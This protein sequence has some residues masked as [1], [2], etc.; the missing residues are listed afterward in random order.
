MR[1]F[2]FTIA[3]TFT[4]LMQPVSVNAENVERILFSGSEL[5]Y[6]LPKGFCNVTESIQGIILKDIIDKQKNPMVPVAQLI[7]SPCEPNITN[8]GYPWGWIGVIK[9]PS[10]LRQETLNKMTVKL[11]TDEDLVEKVLKQLEDKNT[12]VVKEFY[13]VDTKIDSNEQRV[14]W[15]DKDSILLVGNR[16]GQVDGTAIKEV[17]V[18]STTVIDDLFI[19]IF[20]YNLEGAIPSGKQMSELLINN[21]SRLKKLN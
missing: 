3:I 5:L 20:I 11:L 14:I 10:R 19:Y 9:N 7:I 16:A 21:A 18:S 6:P 8:P 12:E 13:G 4:L 2:V 17:F 1:K 15:A